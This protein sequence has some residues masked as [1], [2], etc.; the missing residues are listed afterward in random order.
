MLQ[1]SSPRRI[2]PS[3]TSG[4]PPS[5]DQI[6]CWVISCVACDFS[7]DAVDFVAPTRGSPGVAFARQ[8]AMYLV[9][10]GF[11][12]SFETIGRAF[13]RD[14][15]TVSHACRVV[16]DH[17]DDVRIDCRLAALESICRAGPQRSQGCCQ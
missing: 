4:A 12:L 10:T 9:H 5:S 15:T 14:R 16:E 2:A 8:V 3:G 11:G 17:R 1:F 6:C 13:D 7:L